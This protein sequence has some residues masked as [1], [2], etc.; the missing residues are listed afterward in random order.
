M[1]IDTSGK[2]WK[3][4]N[5]DDLVEYIR[6]LTEQGSPATK[7]AIAKCECGRDHFRLYAD[8]DEGCAKRQCASC[9]KEAF[10]CDG[11]EVS[12]EASLKKAKCHCKKDVFDLA[13]G[14]SLRDTGEIKWLTVGLRCVS[15][16]M[17][18]AYVDWK[19]DY[20]PT[21]HLYSMV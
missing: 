3:G 17:L 1:G 18:G 2:W 21:D 10:I 12:E 20:A 19:I 16:G 11:E 15:C 5:A 9:G 4:Q 14:F 7:F 6:L 8:R 13:V